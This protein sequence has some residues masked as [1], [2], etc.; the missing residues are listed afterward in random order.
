M[1]INNHR[2]FCLAILRL[3][4]DS[5]DSNASGEVDISVNAVREW[6]SKY[7][8]ENVSSSSSIIIVILYN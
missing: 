2:E 8:A 4:D 5:P 1:R 3:V 7:V 6:A